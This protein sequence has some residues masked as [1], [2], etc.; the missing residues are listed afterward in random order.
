MTQWMKRLGILAVLLMIAAPAFGQRISE[1]RID[2]PSTDNDEYFELTGPPSGSLDGFTYLVLGD[3]GSGTIEA[4]IDLT[5]LSFDANGFFV[6][7]ESSFT[8][9]TADFT[10]SL[11]F[12]NSDN[13][14][15]MLVSGFTGANGQD[16]DPDDDCDLDVFPW[17]AI[18]DSIALVEEPNPPTGTECFYG[19][20]IGPESTQA[21]TFVPGHIFRCGNRWFIGAFDPVGGQDTPGAANADLILNLLG[22]PTAGNSVNFQICAKG[23]DGNRAQ[24]LLSCSGTAG[25]PL[26]ASG[27][28]VLPL[29]FDACTSLS[30]SLSVVLTGTVGAVDSGVADTPLLLVPTTPTTPAWAAAF[31]VGGSGFVSVTGPIDFN[32]N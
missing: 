6:A 28:L 11:N 10:T 3:T 9:G 30:L 17:T 27:G 7:A 1:I 25:I 12:E 20:G 31:T 24:V 22:T 16:L 4:V 32:I 15:H 21:G 26:P 18:V 29:T 23:Q 13:V 8:L 5:G 2:Q 14:T 19:L